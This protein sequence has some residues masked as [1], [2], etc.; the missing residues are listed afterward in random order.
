MKLLFI[1][2]SLAFNTRVPSCLIKKLKNQGFNTSTVHVV[3]WLP[4]RQTPGGD[5]WRIHLFHAH[6]EHRSTPGLHIEPPA[7]LP[8][9]TWLSGHFQF[10]PH[11]Q[12][13]CGRPDDSTPFYTASSRREYCAFISPHH[14]KR[15]QSNIRGHCCSTSELFAEV[16]HAL[17]LRLSTK[18][19]PERWDVLMTCEAWSPLKKQLATVRRT[20][21]RRCKEGSSLWWY[22]ESL[23]KEGYWKGVPE[24]SRGGVKTTTYSWTSVRQRSWYW[25]LARSKERTTPP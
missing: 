9:N 13:S 25:T 1:D 16:I 20:K 2:Y 7:V 19:R 21:Q 22:C 11:H 10:Q 4:V 5:G 14:I 15:Y 23:C 6:P 12:H 24:G 17:N 18:A 8:V 3:P